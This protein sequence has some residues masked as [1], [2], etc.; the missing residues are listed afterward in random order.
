MKTIKLIV[1]SFCLLLGNCPVFAESQV[2]EDLKIQ[3][4]DI[5]KSIAALEKIVKTD[6]DKLTLEEFKIERELLSME[7]LALKMGQTLKDLDML[8]LKIDALTRLYFTKE[9]DW[10]TYVDKIFGD[11]AFKPKRKY[12]VEQFRIELENQR[13]LGKSYQDSMKNEIETLKINIYEKTGI[14]LKNVDLKKDPAIPENDFSEFIAG[15]V[16]KIKKDQLTFKQK[17]EVQK[18]FDDAADKYAELKMKNTQ[19][20]K[21]FEENNH[22]LNELC[23]RCPKCC[24]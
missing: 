24:E 13:Q 9:I 11:D 15:E 14:K 4:G 6:E 19:V 2:I 10:H 16:L 20:R 1:L 12:A 23:T 22:A 8:K 3:L 17:Q 5:N 7:I 21:E 18:L